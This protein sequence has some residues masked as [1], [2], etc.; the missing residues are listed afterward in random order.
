MHKYIQAIRI[1]VI[2]VLLSAGII[3]HAQTITAGVNGTVTDASGAVVANAKV[4]ATN[5]DTGV[6]TPTTTNRD[7]IYT[8]PFLQ[9]G[10]YKVTVEAP[11]FTTATYGPFTLETGQNAKVDSKLGVAGQTQQVEVAA[12]LAPLLNTENAQLATTL[13]SRA[14]DSIPMIGRD[15]V[16]LTMFLPGAVSTSPAGFA[17]NSAIGHGGN[18]VSVNGNRQ[19]SNNYLLDGIDINETLNNSPGYNPGP[20]SIGQYQIIS[21]NAP[22]EYGNVNGGDILAQTKSGTNQW[23]GSAYYYL[24]NYNLNANSW[25]NKHVIAPNPIT[26]KTSFTQIQP[27]GTIGGP[28]LHDRLFIF[29]GVDIGRYHSG[30]L[31]NTTVATALERTGDFSELYNKTYMCS[32]PGTTNCGAGNNS[33][34]FQLYNGTSAPIGGVATFA[35][36]PNNKVPVL[37]P[38]LQYLYAHPSLYPLP[39]Q[40]PTASNSPA[41]NNYRSPTKARRYNN[42]Y[43]IRGDY[44]VT[45][46]DNLNI[47]YI[48]SNNGSTSTPQLAITFPSAPLNPVYGVAINEVHTFNASMVN[49]FRAGYTRVQ[50]LGAVTLDTTGVFGTTGNSVVGIPGPQAFAGFSAISEGT[51][52]SPSGISNSGN[53][54]EYATI[55]NAN[56]GTNFVD[57]TFAYGDNFTWLK[58]KH[59]WKFGVTFQRQQQNNFYPGNDGSI[60]GFY[61]LGAATASPNAD[62]NGYN[63]SGYNFADSTINQASFASKG[64]VSGPAGMRSWRDAYFVQ[65]DWKF[66][67]NLTLNLGV[68]YDYVQPIYEVHNR[69]ATVDPNNPSVI[70]TAGTPSTLGFPPG[71]VV[72][73]AATAGYNRSLVNPYYG[74]VEPRIGFSYSVNPKWVWRGGYGIQNYMEGTGA[75]LRMTTNL[76]Y[77]SAFEGSGQAQTTTTGATLFQTQNGFGGGSTA[78]A[79]G[80]VFNIWQK[81]IKPAF[82]GEYSLTTEYQV[83]NT[84]SFQIGYVGES[85]QHLITANSANQLQHPCVINGAFQTITTTSY[86]TACNTVSPAP[87]QLTPTIGYYGTIRQTASNAMMNYNAL[88]AT[89]RQRAWRGLQYTVNY[90]YSRA[91]TNSTGFYGVPSINAQS[92]YAI[93]VYNNHEEYGPVGQDVRNNLNWNLVYD[94]PVG[95]GRQ[96]GA[97]MPYALDLLVGGW[98]VAMTGVEY[99]GFPVNF[100]GGSS[101]AVNGAGTQRP[102]HL[103]KIK[104]VNRGLANWFGT[105][106][107]AT[108]CAA[109][110]V[111]ATG[112]ITTNNDNGLCAYQAASTGTF[113]NSSVGPERTPGYQQYDAS[114]RKDFTI[115][116]EQKLGFGTDASNVFNQSEL[117]NPTNT[118]T[119]STFGAITGVRSG[120]RQLQLWLKYTF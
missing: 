47:R 4:T 115:W 61:F 13:D 11:G 108:P 9:I 103:R 100:A 86:N 12:E 104:I 109:N 84:A 25:G 81:N 40:N 105:D 72:V 23:H 89:F 111:T 117:S 78:A 10:Q 55:G 116:H 36:F 44:K 70:I 59:T 30:G 74:S 68:R 21:A 58:G 7:G 96:Y 42:Q 50:S 97:N 88:Q 49:E 99:S 114:V 64:G 67:P 16:Q 32:T 5:V 85:G 26:P 19:Q 92:A 33:R 27:G 35:A 34:L 31:S 93:N 24:S 90:T 46:R 8:I 2:A 87:Y 53:G 118:I 60:G 75:N 102:N 41:S 43:T 113:G 95:R 106:P 20:D 66:L 98:R 39:N 101:S 91:M 48:Q 76:P 82:I 22:A 18:T 37:N 62:P 107:S 51:P 57:N 38:V 83:S 29:G 119:S 56:T 3:S 112:A 28:L 1:G 79:A 77:Q 69:M 94:L 120:V 17:G 71:T 52:P 80:G 45:N 14:I 73:S 65:D 63:H 54:G 15:L 6:A 110:V